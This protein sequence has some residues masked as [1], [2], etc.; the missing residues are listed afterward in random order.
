MSGERVPVDKERQP[1]GILDAHEIVLRSIKPKER[2]LVGLS[3]LEEALMVASAMIK[4]GGSFV[5][6]L[7]KAL[8]RADPQNAGKIKQTWPDYWKKYLKMGLAGEAK[9]RARC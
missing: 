6:C 5:Q 1:F 8:D 9:E 7:G 2:G 3:N 4:F